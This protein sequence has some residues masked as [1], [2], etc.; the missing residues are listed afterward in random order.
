MIRIDY[1]LDKNKNLVF[2]WSCDLCEVD[3]QALE[4]D[5]GIDSVVFHLR[6]FHG[7][8]E[9]VRFGTI[10]T[11]GMAASAKLANP[12]SPAEDDAVDGIADSMATYITTGSESS[13]A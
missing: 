7:H 11:K 4:P 10:L 9:L 3:D 6:Q 2:R 5:E 8:D 13:P 1:G 12:G